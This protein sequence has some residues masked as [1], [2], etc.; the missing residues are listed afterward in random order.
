M[1]MFKKSLLLLMMFTLSFA[2]EAAESMYCPER[3][4]YI[5]LGMTAD[6]VI[7]ACGEPTTK[8]QS[9]NSAV[10]R[11]PVTQL[12]YTTL[13]RGGTFQGYDSVYQMWSLP[14][15][16]TGTSVQVDIIDDKITGI[17][18]NGASN[19]AMSICGGVGLQIGDNTNAVY[20]AC[21]S[22]TLVNHTYIN[23]PIPAAAKPEVWTYQINQY[24]PPFSLTFVNGTLQSI[25]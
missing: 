8:Q 2:L 13:N 20:S 23:K 4:G 7:A 25:Q 16:S 18:I 10:Q 9:S 17:K 3:H 15:G 19:N 6:Q 11:V 22:P 14:S 1:I 21:G 5:N 12:I 24:Q